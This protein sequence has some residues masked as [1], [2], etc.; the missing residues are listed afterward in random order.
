MKCFVLV[1]ALSAAVASPVVASA[2]E[3]AVTP[4]SL[5]GSSAGHTY[6]HR[7]GA[8][9]E[10][11]DEA[12]RD[13]GKAAARMAQP[14]DSS[15]AAAGAAGGLLGALVVGAISGYVQAQRNTRALMA[16]VEN[17][18]VVDG[19]AVRRIEPVEGAA[20]DELQQPALHDAMALR[21]GAVEPRDEQVRIFGDE[22]TSQQPVMFGFAGDLDVVSLSVQALPPLEKTEA[23]PRPRLP[24]QARTARAPRALAEDALTAPEGSGLV[25]VRIDGLAEHANRTLTFVRAGE[26]PDTPAWVADQQPDR[27]SVALSGRAAVRGAIERTTTAAFAVPPGRWRLASLS[28]GLFAVSLC[29]AA[30]AFDLKAGETVFAGRFDM[31]SAAAAPQMKLEP[32]TLPVAYAALSPV[33]VVWSPAGPTACEGTYLYGSNPV[34][35]ASP[36]VPQEATAAVGATAVENA[37]SGA[38]APEGDDAQTVPEKPTGE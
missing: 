10:Q 30:P 23:T 21:I 25:I 8:T 5:T 38:A 15:A 36:V 12:L 14:A 11:H 16:N 4:F 22:L 35:T 34:P 7:A 24:R 2:Q 27:F 19:W 37:A 33:P 31:T 13:C 32:A 20:L 18:M 26:S 28:Q 3:A 29:R 6:F 17:C 1:A 9:L